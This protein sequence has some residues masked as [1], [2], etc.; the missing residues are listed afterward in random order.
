LQTI[1][2]LDSTKITEIKQEIMNTISDSWQKHSAL[3]FDWREDDWDAIQD[4]K[5]Q[6]FK[7]DSP[8]NCAENYTAE[9]AQVKVYIKQKE[10]VESK[11]AENRFTINLNVKADGSFEDA[12]PK[13][14]IIH[15][16]GHALGF[17]DEDKRFDT[18]R[19]PS[20]QV[21]QYSCNDIMVVYN[22]KDE[23]QNIAKNSVKK[24]THTKWQKQLFNSLSIMNEC[25]FSNSEIMKRYDF[26][27]LISGSKLGFNDINRLQ[28]FYGAPATAETS[29]LMKADQFV[30]GL[31]LDANDYE[32]Y[33]NGIANS[34]Y[35]PI[36]KS[37]LQTILSS[38]LHFSITNNG[39]SI[40]K[41]KT[42]LF[43]HEAT[44]VDYP[45]FIPRETSPVAACEETGT[46]SQDEN[47]QQ[48]IQFDL[49]CDTIESVAT[50]KQITEERSIYYKADSLLAIQMYYCKTK[51]ED[52][53]TF[54]EQF[55]DKD[56]CLDLTD[57]FA[58]TLPTNNT[59]NL[60]SNG[61]NELV[62]WL[63]ETNQ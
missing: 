45:E 21:S 26:G 41:T 3:K 56:V 47:N 44:T 18:F 48:K 61:K 9:Y 46:N 52:T 5:G 57:N 63:V 30:T 6:L 13:H 12:Y 39:R 27:T 34:S 15:E 62:F 49:N 58:A 35:S 31:Y 33:E 43:K 50:H 60:F 24:I 38:N 22:P 10:E 1:A 25:V 59:H 40:G 7:W 28:Y 19:S 23:N 17:P 36:E 8:S 55:T 4:G 51:K 42:V 32:Y 11:Q 16:F 53:T 37:N 2:N 14:K 29:H 54:K 20:S